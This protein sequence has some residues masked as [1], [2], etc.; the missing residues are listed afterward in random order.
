LIDAATSTLAH[1]YTHLD[2]EGAEE[3]V[4]HREGKGRGTNSSGGLCRKGDHSSALSTSLTADQRDTLTLH[5]FEGY[6]FDEIALKLGQSFGNIR[7]HYY[8]GLDKL[9]KAAFSPGR[10]PSRNDIW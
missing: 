4:D 1:F 10:L 7:N 8:R 6:T 5:F 2:L 3:V 9:R